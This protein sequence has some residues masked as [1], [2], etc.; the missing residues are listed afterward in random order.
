MPKKSKYKPRPG[1]RINKAAAETVG[2]E[3]EKM[4]SAGVKTTAANLLKRATKPGTHLHNLFD[5]DDAS[6]ADKHRLEYAGYLIR[7][8][9]EIDLTTTMP[10]RS[11]HPIQFERQEASEFVSRREVIRVPDQLE[12]VER[13]IYDDIVAQVSEAESLGLMKKKGWKAIARAVRNHPV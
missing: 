9:I 2:S 10:G 4:E 11:F 13:R 12:Q 1:A 7:M 3:L 6:A 5:W 8:V